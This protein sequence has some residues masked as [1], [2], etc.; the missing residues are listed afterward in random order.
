M[1]QNVNSH[2]N[3]FMILMYP[4]LASTVINFRHAIPSIRLFWNKLSYFIYISLLKSKD[5]KYDH[6]AIVTPKM[7]NNNF[8]FLSISSHVVDH[9]I[10]WPFNF[11]WVY[12]FMI[13]F[14]SSLFA[15]HTLRL[16]DISLGSLFICNF[17]LYFL[18]IINK[19]QS[20]ALGVFHH[21]SF[22]NCT[23]LVLLDMSCISCKL[24]VRSRTS[25]R[26]DL[27][28]GP[29]GITLFRMWCH[30]FPSVDP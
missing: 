16:V 22:A 30:V 25:V 19:I 18:Y 2:K 7:I 5:Q 12:N 10:F 23:P 21:L 15:C 26:L 11:W 17:L 9:H 14:I 28:G 24:T 3:I 8:H 4:L 20:I 1:L 29:G 27:G 6:S 13:Q